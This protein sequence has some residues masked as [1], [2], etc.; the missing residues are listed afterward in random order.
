M[1]KEECGINEW[2]FASVVFIFAA[3]F[4]FARTALTLLA[5]NLFLSL[6]LFGTNLIESDQ[7]RDES[8]NCHECVVLAEKSD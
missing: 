6:G 8:K 5:R 2:K 3:I 1:M 7:S 4:L